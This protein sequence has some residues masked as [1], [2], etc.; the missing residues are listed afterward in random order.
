MAGWCMPAPVARS[1]K[2]ARNTRSKPATAFALVPDAK[3]VTEQTSAS[4]ITSGSTVVEVRRGLRAAVAL[5]AAHPDLPIL[6]LSQYVEQTYV[7]ELL[8]AD[9]AAVPGSATC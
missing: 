6:V 5:R 1:A 9:T 2:S 3:V 7:A 8:D 4:P